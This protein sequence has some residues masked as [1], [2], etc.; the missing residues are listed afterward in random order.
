MDSRDLLRAACQTLSGVLKVHT[1][2]PR[3]QRW[4]SQA[5]PRLAAST[6]GAILHSCPHDLVGRMAMV[7][8]AAHNAQPEVIHAHTL[9]TL[10]SSPVAPR[11]TDAFNEA[12]QKLVALLSQPPDPSVSHLTELV[13]ACNA[14]ARCAR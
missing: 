11:S 12:S 7:L 6:V 14:L 4:L 13:H 1:D 3:V 2:Q 9:T 10:Q 8:D 5:A